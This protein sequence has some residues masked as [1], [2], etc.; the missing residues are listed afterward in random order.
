MAGRPIPPCASGADPSPDVDDVS[1]DVHLWSALERTSIQAVDLALDR[2]GELVIPRDHLVDDPGHQLTRIKRS[3]GCLIGKPVVEP[4]NGGNGTAMD[5]YDEAGTGH[6]MELPPKEPGTERFGQL[7]LERL[8]GQVQTF[9][10]LDQASS[11]RHGLDV[12]PVPSIKLQGRCN[13]IQAA[14]GLEID[15]DPDQ[16]PFTDGREILVREVDF[17]IVPVGIEA[18]GSDPV[19]Q[20]AAARVAAAPRAIAEIRYC[21]ISMDRSTIGSGRCGRSVLGRWAIIDVSLRRCGGCLARG[22][23]DPLDAAQR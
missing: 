6:D 16:A 20:L 18:P 5:R 23:L 17:L 9:R 19:D 13:G 4:L 11:G 21:T 3:E 10:R 7:G 14:T 22:L 12:M 1:E 2:F 8:H 15:V